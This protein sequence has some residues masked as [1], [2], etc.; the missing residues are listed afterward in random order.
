V[1]AVQQAIQQDAHHVQEK[2]KILPLLIE[3]GADLNAA[4]STDQWTA[5]HRAAMYNADFQLVRRLVEAGADVNAVDNEHCTTL[6][7]AA[8]G[9][10]VSEIIRRLAAEGTQISQLCPNAPNYSQADLVTYLLANGARVDEVD[11]NGF[12]ALHHAALSN[13]DP[14]VIDLLVT[15]GAD[16]NAKTGRHIAPIR[17]SCQTDEANWTPLH[18][19][20]RYNS[21]ADVIS[22]LITAGADVNA[23]TSKGETPYKFATHQE[24]PDAICLLLSVGAKLTIGADESDANEKLAALW[25]ASNK[26]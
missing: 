15:N 20:A 1:T 23:L 26:N 18:L 8:K 13:L 25:L 6:H 19:A 17:G 22:S 12:T 10:A 9:S 3:K 5:L 21:T 7:Y 24:F 16:V 11:V 14:A 2:I 4:D